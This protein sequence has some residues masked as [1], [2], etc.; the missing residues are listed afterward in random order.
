MTQY[1]MF[2]IGQPLH[3]FDSDK[4]AGEKIIVQNLPTGTPFITLDGHEIKLDEEDLMICHQSGPMCIAGVYGG[5]ESGITENSKNIFIESAYF[6]PTSVRKTSKRHHLKTDAAFRYERGCDVDMTLYALKR[7]ANLLQNIAGATHFSEIIDLYPYEVEKDKILLS[8]VQ[9]E[10]LIGKKIEDNEVINIL[11]SL[12]FN[13]T[14]QNTEH[15]LVEV[16]HNK[17]DVTRPV[18]LIE[19]ILRIYGYNQIE[20]PEEFSFVMQKTPQKGLTHFQ[21]RSLYI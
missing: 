7:A 13:I 4:I 1:V 17:S 18:D 5:I 19:E 2:E 11:Q 10:E 20:L 15:L 6:H 21:E 9:V 12:G 14:V 3:A 16:P 8:L